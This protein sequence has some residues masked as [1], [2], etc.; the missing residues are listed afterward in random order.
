MTTNT[1]MSKHNTPTG[2]EKRRCLIRS[3]DG[4]YVD[5]GTYTAVEAETRRAS[6]AQRSGERYPVV[7]KW[8]PASR[9]DG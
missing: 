9:F 3:S 5:V 6:L 2:N 8:F 7:I 4:S 1:L